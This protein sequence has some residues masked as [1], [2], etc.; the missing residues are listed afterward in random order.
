MVFYYALAVFTIFLGIS[1]YFILVWIYDTCEISKTFYR[2]FIRQ[3]IVMEKA[4]IIKNLTKK[5]KLY[6]DTKERIFD[7]VSPKSYGKDFYALMDVNF[8][9]NHGEVVGF[10][11]INGSGKSTLSNII[12]GIVPESSG[13]IQVNGQTALIAVAAGLKNDLSGRDNI[14]L[15]LLML[16]FGK[17]EIKN[18]RSEERR[19]GKEGRYS[20]AMDKEKE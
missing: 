2:L 4:I 10:I 12:A 6:N 13:S 11:G 5:Y 3:V 19:V 20:R 18:L 14:E 7:L 8:E 9:A 17:E 16:G 1:N 15:K